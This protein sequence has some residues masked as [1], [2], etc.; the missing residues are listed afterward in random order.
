MAKAKN[1]ILNPGGRHSG[2]AK[3]EYDPK[4][5]SIK[6]VKGIKAAKGQNPNG[7]ILKNNTG[8]KGK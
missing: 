1:D 6:G 4:L 7:G 2:K 8:K 3:L 5:T